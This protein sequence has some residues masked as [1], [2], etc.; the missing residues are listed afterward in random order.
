MVCVATA[1]MRGASLRSSNRTGWRHALC[2]AHTQ[3]TS[4]EKVGF[5]TSYLC[6]VNAGDLVL[7]FHY[8]K[9]QF[10]NPHSSQS[11]FLFGFGGPLRIPLCV[12]WGLSLISINFWLALLLHVVLDFTTSAAINDGNWLNVCN[13]VLFTVFCSSVTMVMSVPSFFYRLPVDH[14]HG[15]AAPEWVG[16]RTPGMSPG[17]RSGIHDVNSFLLLCH[18]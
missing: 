16:A 14:R 3:H 12:I 4:N 2:V 17:K 11:R 1:S 7:D 9:I 6:R 8:I 5:F 13:V 15:D 18:V 10:S